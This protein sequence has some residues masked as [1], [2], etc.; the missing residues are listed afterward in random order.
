MNRR[1][2]SLLKRILNSKGISFSLIIAI[3]IFFASSYSGFSNSYLKD[4]FEIKP[5]KEIYAKVIKVSDGDTIHLL[6]ENNTK[7]K[8]RLQGIDAPENKQEYGQE[9]KNFLSSMIKDKAV[10]AVI[11]DKDKYDRFVATI[12]LNKMNINRAM[13]A[14]GY[15]H[16]YRDF[17]T[18]YIKEE[19]NAKK[20]RLGLWQSD[21]VKSPS[22]FRKENN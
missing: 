20:N 14:N 11:E 7:Y 9:A 4:I 15:A 10:K 6:D 18:K 5:K 2:F 22:D 21:N 8:I 1:A 16:A 3:L 12:Y 19:V 17:S 13:V